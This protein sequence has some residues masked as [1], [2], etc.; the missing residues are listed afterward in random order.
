MQ[1]EFDGSL[2]GN[3]M[4][5]KE[6]NGT[7]IKGKLLAL[8]VLPAG[9]TWGV[10]AHELAP[11]LEQQKL[12]E[13]LATVGVKTG[14]SVAEVTSGIGFR[15]QHFVEAV[16]PKGVVYGIAFHQENVDK[17]GEKAT[18]NNWNNVR[19]TLGSHAGEKVNLPD[20]EID[21]AVVLDSYHHF[22]AAEVLANLKK[23]L[24]P[25]GRMA[26]VEVYT[27]V[28]AASLFT[29]PHR[30]HGEASLA[31]QARSRPGDRPVRAKTRLRS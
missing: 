24:G 31:R 1:M 21:W 18:Q 27:P 29:C 3:T 22:R 28:L 20:G 13:L 14:D 6:M 19:P 23:S 15:L 9:L 8:L 10:S 25:N 30:L 7:A 17:I 16:G 4:K 26:I 11:P 2:M 12:S 5:L